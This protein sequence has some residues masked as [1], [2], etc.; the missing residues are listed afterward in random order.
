M[1]EEFMGTVCLAPEAI[2]K[3]APLPRKKRKNKE[4]INR[5]NVF[6]D[7]ESVANSRFFSTSV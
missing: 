2:N 6:D 3:F 7:I 5:S 1:T 4:E